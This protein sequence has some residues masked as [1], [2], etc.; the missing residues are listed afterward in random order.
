MEHRVNSCEECWL[1][2]GL[3]DLDACEGC[4]RYLCEECWG[5]T[6]RKCADCSEAA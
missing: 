4:H 3:G 6:A 2:F 5:G 1:E